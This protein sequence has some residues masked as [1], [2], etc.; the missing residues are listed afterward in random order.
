MTV[1]AEVVLYC[2][3]MKFRDGA[4]FASGELRS[5]AFSDHFRMGGDELEETNFV[6]WQLR[7]GVVWISRGVSDVRPNS[8]LHSLLGAFCAG[9][10][11]YRSKER[12]EPLTSSAECTLKIEHWKP[13]TYRKQRHAGSWAAGAPRSFL[14]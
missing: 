8:A 10:A 3:V 1:C 7:T 13:D 12:R 6:N 4:F 14:T 2:A 5:F 11:I 9:S